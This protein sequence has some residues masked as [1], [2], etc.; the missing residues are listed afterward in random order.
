MGSPEDRLDIERTILAVLEEFAVSVAPAAPSALR[1][2]DALR[3]GRGVYAEAQR[4]NLAIVFCVVDAGGVPLVLH[5]MD[6]AFLGS[7][8][9]ARAKAWTAA[10]Y[11]RPTHAFF[12]ACQPGRELYGMQHAPGVTIVGGG[13]P[14]FRGGTLV[15]GVG[16]SGGT[17]EQDMVLASKALEFL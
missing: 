11:Q 12:E 17:K 8:E 3:M 14:C 5:R 13:Y 15:G 6:N 16:V 1:L 2:E 7:V 9:L 10:A 4:M